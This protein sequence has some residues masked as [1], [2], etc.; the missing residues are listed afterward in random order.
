MKKR[1]SSCGTNKLLTLFYNDKQKSD[2]KTSR[3]KTCILQHHATRRRNCSE[4]IRRNARKWRELNRDHCRARSRRYSE[5]HK[6]QTRERAH[7]YRENNKEQMRERARNY[8]ENNKDKIRLAA[9][10]LYKNN[11]VEMCAKTAEYKRTHK[12]EARATQRIYEEANR[13]KIQARRREYHKNN[14]DKQC[15]RRRVRRARARG[16]EEHFTVAMARHV[17]QLWGNK[18]AMCGKTEKQ[19]GSPLAIDHW[20]P[21]SKGHP[22]TIRN[23]VLMC[24]LCNSR[25][26]VYL[27]HEIYDEAIIHSIERRLKAHEQ[28]WAKIVA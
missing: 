23:A 26:Q 4:S 14:P 27:P 11:R 19:E 24:C 28:S 16:V 18:C 25:K 1:C 3:C 17:C 6:E 7:N 13:G 10:R 5:T 20:L 9:Q 12:A 2:G 8:R 15:E 21:L 22:L